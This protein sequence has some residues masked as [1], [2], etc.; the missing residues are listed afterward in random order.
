MTLLLF[1]RTNP[2][3][4]VPIPYSYR[5][6]YIPVLVP[7]PFNRSIREGGHQ[8][9]ADC[10]KQGCVAKTALKETKVGSRA[11]EKTMKKR[12]RVKLG[13]KYQLVP[14]RERGVEVWFRVL[15]G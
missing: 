4:A 11:L 14:M 10:W 13:A 5:I 6:P 7:S 1:R 15:D 8:F 3:A 2:P 9:C 12:T